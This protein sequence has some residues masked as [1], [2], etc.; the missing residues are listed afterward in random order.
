MISKDSRSKRA[1]IRKEQKKEKLHYR[2]I[3][4][5][6][7]ISVIYHYF[8]SPD[9]IGSDPRYTTYIFI[10]HTVAGA[11]GLGVYRGQFLL[12][13]F[14]TNKGIGIRAFIL[15][16]YT[17]QG[18]LFSFFSIGTF[19]R[20]GWEYANYQQAIHSSAEEH[21]YEIDRFW[22]KDDPSI[23][24]YMDGH[25]EKIEVSYKD[26]KAYKDENPEDFE[27]HLRTRKGIWNYYLL[28]SW[29]ISRK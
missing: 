15:V 9:T 11:I 23:D 24:F 1:Y 26:I 19:A 22:T 8:I 14:V 25:F 18:L 13:R 5:L 3:I 28:E 7:I 20:A 10:L 21:V 16:F 12:Y 17:I 27:L 29:S 6:M 2:I 4:G